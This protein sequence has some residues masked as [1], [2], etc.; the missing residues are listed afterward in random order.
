MLIIGESINGTIPKVGQAIQE[1]NEA[2]LQGAGKDSVRVRR[3]D[4]RCQRGSGRGERGRG[5]PLA[6]P[7]CPAGSPHSP[8][9]RQRQPGCPQGGPCRLSARRNFPSSTPSQGRRKNGRS[10][11]LLFSRRGARSLFSAWMIR[12]FQKRSKD[13]IAIASRLFERL[14]QA[15]HAGRLHL[16]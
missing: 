14:I 2:F 4:A 11:S 7:A 13:R 15:G 5:S 12:E 10:F 8:D 16:F 3:P 6:D 1:K 9:D